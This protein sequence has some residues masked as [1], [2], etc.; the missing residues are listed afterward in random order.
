MWLNIVEGLKRIG[1]RIRRSKKE[2]RSG[3]APYPA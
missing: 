1:L 3:A 2:E